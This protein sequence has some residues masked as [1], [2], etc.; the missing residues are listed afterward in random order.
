ME[1]FEFDFVEN[2]HG[3]LLLVEFVQVGLDSRKL[4]DILLFGRIGQYWFVK[5]GL[6]IAL[7]DILVENLQQ[8]D[9]GDLGDLKGQLIH[10][11]YF[12]N[13]P[14]VKII[15]MVEHIV[16]VQTEVDLAHEDS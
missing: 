13:R 2:D 11:H 6:A 12:H 4:N 1:L 16:I 3:F 10:K 14:P 7:L 9:K 15:K 8:G 5:F